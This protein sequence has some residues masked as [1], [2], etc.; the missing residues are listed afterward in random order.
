MDINIEK[1]IRNMVRI[2]YVS[3]VNT[4]NGSIRATFPDKNNTVSD[5]LPV[6]TRGSAKNKDYWLPDINEQVVCLLLPNGEN[7]GAGFCLG[8]YFSDTALPVVSNSN[9]RRLDFLDGTYIEYDRS[10][11][12]LNIN[13][14]GDIKIN[15]KTISLN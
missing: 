9:K 14:V 1:I 4:Q 8:T 11:H 5:E 15:G 3:S 2:G 12:E 7:S 13:C 10:T 6:L